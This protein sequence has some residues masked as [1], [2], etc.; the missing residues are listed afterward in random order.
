MSA[1]DVEPTGVLSAHQGRGQVL[2]RLVR[3]RGG[4][5]GLVVVMVLVVV[6]VLAPQLAPYDPEAQDIASRFAAPSAQHLLGTDDLGRDTF[7]R[8]IVATRTAMLVVLPA[9]GLG[10]ALGTVMGLVA[11]YVGRW[12]DSALVTVNDTLQAFPGVVLALVVIA[13]VG[14][15]LRN[16]VVLIA[17]TTAPAYFRLIRASMIAE[18]EAVYVDAERALGAGTTRI[19]GHILPNIAPPVLVLT[20]LDVPGVMAIDA[21]LSFLGLGVQPPTPSWG[22]MLATGFQNIASSPWPVIFPSVVLALATVGFTFF[23]EAL[24]DALDVRAAEVDV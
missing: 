11:G 24:R 21:G 4:A 16:E 6:A 17:L 23:G 2:R 7:S 5:F 10:L 19:L 3:Q 8:L 1:L 9:L 18:R 20:A 15:S 12:I 22:V 14:P 13:L